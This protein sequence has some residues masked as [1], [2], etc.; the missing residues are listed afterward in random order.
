VFLSWS[1]RRSFQLAT[2]LKNELQAILPGIEAWMSSADVEPGEFW[3]TALTGRLEA[4]RASVLCL[5]PENT[6]S[7]WILFEAGALMAAADLSRVIPYTLQFEPRELEAPLSLFQGCTVN[8]AGT[9]RL[10]A[11]LSKLSGAAAAPD[12]P[13]FPAWWEGVGKQIAA[14]PESAPASDIL[15]SLHPRDFAHPGLFA[16][17]FGA[18][19][20]RLTQRLDQL[21]EGTVSIFS[22]EVQRLE[23]DLFS[24]LRAGQL[25]RM[26]AV[27][28]TT[29]PG[30]LLTRNLRR[31]ERQRFVRA[32]GR[33]LRLFVVS[34]DDMLTKRFVL[35]LRALLLQE[36][37]DGVTTGLT[38]RDDLHGQQA[39]DYILYDT[40]A[41]VVES[42][43]ADRAYNQGVSTIHFKKR[44]VERFGSLFLQLWPDTPDAPVVR[45]RAAFTSAPVEQLQTASGRRQLRAQL[46]DIYAA[47]G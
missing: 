1:G 27:D 8:R 18:E 29:N 17:F 32:G 13:A 38:F 47:R 25:S 42:V 5:T 41:V 26:A 40:F 46:D 2:I 20:G 10:V 12:A 34:R 6:R 9:E 21:T 30:V 45:A 33:I 22:T 19:S 11:A 44:D 31:A 3:A 39:Q 24:Y 37:A 43:Q 7:P 23:A 28:L 14:I 15:R 36:E 4:F 16:E 35:D